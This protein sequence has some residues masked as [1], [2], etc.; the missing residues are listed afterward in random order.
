MI[1]SDDKEKEYY[2]NLNNII[3]LLRLKFDQRLIELTQVYQTSQE[4]QTNPRALR[5]EH[6]WFV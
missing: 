4:E 6:T 5:Q 3:R 2:F 1:I